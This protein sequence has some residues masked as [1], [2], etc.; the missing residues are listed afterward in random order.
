M[1]EGLVR[2]A[3]TLTV[4]IDI[5]SF[6]E[7]AQLGVVLHMMYII[8]VGV[9]AMG[10]P[11]HK[12][13][14]KTLC[15]NS[16]P[17]SDK[18]AVDIRKEDGSLYDKEVPCRLV[19]ELALSGHLWDVLQHPCSFWGMDKGSECM[20]AGKGTRWARLRAAL[21]GRGG[22]LEQIFGTREAL[23]AALEGEHGPFLLEVMQFLGVTD[24]SK[25]FPVR[26]LPE[27]PDTSLP[28]RSIPCKL[29]ILTRVTVVTRQIDTLTKTKAVIS[30]QLVE[31]GSR[32]S[33]DRSTLCF[34]SLVELVPN[35]NYCDK[36]M[37][38]RGAVHWTT[39]VKQPLGNLLKCVSETRK[40]HI[41]L[42]L[43]HYW[44][45][46]VNAVGK[47]GSGLHAKVAELLGQ[48]RLKPLL[49]R[50]SNGLERQAEAV[51]SRWLMVQ[52]TVK[53]MDFKRLMLV[54]LLIVG[55]AE[56]TDENKI[57]VLQDVCGTRGF[58]DEGRIRF[59]KLK[60]G[61]FFRF[62]ISPVEILY[63][64]VTSL[65]HTL[66][67]QPLLAASAHRSECGSSSMR[68]LGS[69]VRVVDLVLRRL[70]WVN[71]TEWVLDGA[72]KKSP[73]YVAR[74]LRDEGKHPSALRG[75]AWTRVR[76]LGHR[77]VLGVECHGTPLLSNR[78]ERQTPTPAE[79]KESKNTPKDSF[80]RLYGAFFQPGMEK[81][82]TQ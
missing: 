17:A 5:S 50:F 38:D 67:F 68:G 60:V 79:N 39:G 82:V 24:Q 32:I 15:L 45:K 8:D 28:V 34:Y 64:A 11:V 37:I 56:G 62:M 57:K 51:V 49:E 4:N 43:K 40:M 33:T 71:A 52:N 46:V 47:N 30:E 1:K 16:L 54:C 42:I 29:K 58:V 72:T 9:D 74:Y 10:Q 55:F 13:V 81:V 78:L 53:Q 26:P 77:G 70:L 6:N 66:A 23:H 69:M 21:L 59:K 25:S 35:G 73:R 75:P 80:L 22:P 18:K 27:R 7:H 36:H 14:A 44:G 19:M 76:K 61:T 3:D 65:I 31:V 41:H 12:V 2:S 48:E 20:G 63:M